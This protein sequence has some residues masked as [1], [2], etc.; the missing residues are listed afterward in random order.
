MKKT[1]DELRLELSKFPHKDSFRLL[2][3]QEQDACKG[4]QGHKEYKT[5]TQ[6]Y[7]DIPTI[8]TPPTY[9]LRYFFGN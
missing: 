5:T 9:T 4:L 7:Q 6:K 3:I 1:I 2:T 8:S